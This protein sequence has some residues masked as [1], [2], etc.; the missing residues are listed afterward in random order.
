MSF[1]CPFL[2]L[3]IRFKSSKIC[4]Q[5][6]CRHKKSEPELYAIYSPILWYVI[7]LPDKSYTA[8]NQSSMYIVLFCGMWSILTSPVLWYAD[9]S[10]TALH[11]PSQHVPHCGM[12]SIVTNPTL[13]Y[14]VHCDKNYT[15]VC[16]PSWQVLHCGMLSIVRSPTLYVIHRDK[17]YIVVCYPSWQSY[18][19]VCCPSY[20]YIDYTVVCYPSW[21][22]LH[23]GMLS[24]V[25]VTAI[26]AL[27][28]IIYL[29]LYWLSCGD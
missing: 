22:V 2:I 21:Q 18:T 28:V 27:P 7:L 5:V 23:C 17:S 6:L 11:Y 4:W 19:V 1:L 20:Y 26:H 3:K 15:V 16:C 25:P 10:Y 12:L 29:L 8:L 13:W 9:K 14:V 24:I